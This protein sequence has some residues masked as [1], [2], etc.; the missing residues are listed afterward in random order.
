M[1]VDAL[2]FVLPQAA[3]NV[4]LCS[5]CFKVKWVYTILDATKVIDHKISRDFPLVR[6]VRD[7][8]S[9]TSVA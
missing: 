9:T 3:A 7:S 5:Y 2:V 6:E 1:S 4:F 8:M